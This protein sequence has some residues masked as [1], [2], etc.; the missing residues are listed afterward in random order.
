MDT[1]ARDRVATWADYA[2]TGQPAGV[3]DCGGPILARAPHRWGAITYLDG[4]CALCGWESSR[5]VRVPDP[6]PAPACTPLHRTRRARQ[7]HDTGLDVKRIA[8]GERE[9]VGA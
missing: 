7:V 6:E 9:E 4:E 5:P 2:R 1:T 3:C 8:A